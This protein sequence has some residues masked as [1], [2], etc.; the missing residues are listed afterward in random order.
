MLAEAEKAVKSKMDWAKLL[1]NQRYNPNNYNYPGV[2]PLKAVRGDFQKDYDRIVFSSP[3]RRLQNKTQVMPLP[4]S[5]FVH[6][7]LTHSLE[8]S[9][10][11]RTLGVMAGNKI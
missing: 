6:T 2:L 1:S 9:C 8:T 3:F 4:E 7:R 10:V 11:G 5:D